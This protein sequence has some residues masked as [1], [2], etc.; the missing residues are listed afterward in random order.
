MLILH[1]TYDH[2]SVAVVTV[3]VHYSFFPLLIS[4]KNML[5]SALDSICQPPSFV[6]LYY[7]WISL[8]FLVQRLVVFDF[9]NKW[10]KDL[11]NSR[12][13]S[14]TCVDYKIGTKALVA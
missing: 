7:K 9:Q 6:T 3:T 1:E 14:L 13:I 12:L 4:L 2:W 5:L 11:K 10:E 8:Y